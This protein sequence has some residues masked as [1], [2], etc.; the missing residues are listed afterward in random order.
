MQA[1]RSSTRRQLLRGSAGA[2]VGLPLL[3]S[4]A[5]GAARAATAAP[6]RLILMSQTHG[7][8][9]RYLHG[10]AGDA[11]PQRRTLFTGH[12]IAWG[13][14]RS[15]VQ[16]GKRRISHILSA[17]AARF[18]AGLVEKM[19]VLRGFDTVQKSGHHRTMF[20]NLWEH[21][22]GIPSV[23][24]LA[25][26]SPSYYAGTS[27]KER[28]LVVGG[29][30]CSFFH[31]N[32]TSRSGSVQRL[33]PSSDPGQL[34][35]RLF[36]DLRPSAGGAPPPPP[37]PEAMLV[38]HV[39][40]TYRSLRQSNQRLSAADARRLD[41]H[42]EML[43][44]VER[45]VKAAPAVGGAACA[46]PVRS[47]QQFAQTTRRESKDGVRARDARDSVTLYRLY[48]DIITAALKCG[49]T[50]IVA[51]HTNEYSDPFS[52]YKGGWHGLAHEGG[53]LGGRP[54]FA[55]AY[56]RFFEAVFLE[57]AARLDEPEAEGRTYLDNTLMLWTNEHGAR[58]H[59]PV[60]KLMITFGSAGG[61]FKTGLLVDYRNKTP[62]SLMGKR[63]GFDYHTGLTMNQWWA[64][65]LH[66]LRIPSA[67]WS[68][69]ALGMGNG[70]GYGP[71]TVIAQD[72]FGTL[73][74]GLYRPQV[75]SEAGAPLPVIAE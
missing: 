37:G 44:E 32:P 42:L 12:E 47:N 61:H 40:A 3:P 48:V 56:Q 14:I 63:G 55:D 62:A 11:L 38:D 66:A 31:S 10:S 52:D 17:D 45:R 33:S 8:W 18:T 24:Q 73:T 43:F 69:Y 53:E 70:K 30:S 64:N 9:F 15:Q 54:V 1:R 19:N 6:P 72:G 28:A 29:E 35:D 16:D 5:P 65:V 57:L 39:L 25:A 13:P 27:F 59:N 20:G 23:D 60:D 21:A 58:S 41:A 22:E 49:L 68:R 34:W 46:P 75:L 74:P 7:A 67:E 4:L 71:M 2:L 36:K 50:R 51:L 26:W